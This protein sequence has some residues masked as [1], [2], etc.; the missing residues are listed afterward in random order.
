MSNRHANIWNEQ[1]GD[2]ILGRKLK[3][4]S[5]IMGFLHFEAN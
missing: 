3:F 1:E 4:W 5:S 2:E